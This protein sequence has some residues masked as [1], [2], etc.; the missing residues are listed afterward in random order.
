ME[1]KTANKLLENLKL[2]NTGA[3][4]WNVNVTAKLKKKLPKQHFTKIHKNH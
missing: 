3:I 4:E 1:Q 2:L